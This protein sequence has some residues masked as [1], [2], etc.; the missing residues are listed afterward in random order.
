MQ[1][2]NRNISG[3]L[4]ILALIVFTAS[5]CQ[6]G[7]PSAITSLSDKNGSIKLGEAVP[8]GNFSLVVEDFSARS[9]TI[10]LTLIVQNVD[11]AKRIFRYKRS[12]ISVEDD[13]GNVYKPEY[14]ST[15][16]YED[17]QVEIEPGDAVPFRSTFAG[18]R[19]SRVLPRYAG[20]IPSEA[21]NLLVTFDGF[22]PY[23]G[24]TIEVDL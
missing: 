14:G 4:W 8:A 2:R 1:A 24:T 20:V 9:D 13:L 5:A 3:L 15:G 23:Q 12:A 6:S 22:G 19:G 16:L 10:Y 18:S 21:S 11:T 17:V 7:A